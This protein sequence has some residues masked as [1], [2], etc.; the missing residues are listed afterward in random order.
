ML[1]LKLFPPARGGGNNFKN[2]KKE[3][4]SI[5]DSTE[6]YSAMYFQCV[7]K[8]MPWISEEEDTIV[9]ICVLTGAMYYFTDLTRM[10]YPYSVQVGYMTCSHYGS[11]TDATGIVKTGDIRTPQGVEGR[12]VLLVDE[13]CETGSTLMAA[14]NILEDMGAADVKT[15]A[16][17][18]RKDAKQKPDFSAF[19]MSSDYWLVGFGMDDAG[20]LGRNA[21]NVWGFK[22]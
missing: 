6:I 11:G 15:C 20:G 4:K 10:I 3:K 21:P 19:E 12:R 14:K 7:K 18:T 2:M 1:S 9:A 17:I 16:L 8:I 5:I 22:P 13:I